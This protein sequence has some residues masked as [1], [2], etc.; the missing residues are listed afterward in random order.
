MLMVNVFMLNSILVV[1]LLCLICKW[2]LGI[3]CV[4]I[5]KMISCIIDVIIVQNRKGIRLLVCV[6]FDVMVSMK[7]SS[8]L[9]SDSVVVILFLWISLIL[10]YGVRCRQMKKKLENIMVFVNR[11][12]VQVIMEVVMLGM[13]WLCSIQVVLLQW[14]MCCLCIF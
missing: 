6:M 2:Q 9:V 7:L 4:S 14:L 10:L 5:R 1:I 13:G 3:S 11:C 8:V 12:E